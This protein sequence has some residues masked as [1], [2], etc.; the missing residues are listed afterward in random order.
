MSFFRNDCISVNGFNEDFIGWGREDSEFAV[1]LI[2]SG[3]L[4]RNVRFSAIACHLGHCENTRHSLVDND[5]ILEQSIASK[6]TRCK[7]GIDKYLINKK[8]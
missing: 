3:I 4:R 8:L 7:N 5:R 1:R 2:N 6:L